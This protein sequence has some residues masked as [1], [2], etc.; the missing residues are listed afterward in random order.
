M[1][2]FYAERSPIFLAAR[3]NA[4]R[5]ANRGVQTGQGTPI[6]VV[7]PTPNPWVPL[8]ILALGRKAAEV[9]QADV[10][11]L[12]DQRPETLPQ[13]ERSK[14]FDRE[15]ARTDPGGQRAGVEP[16]SWPTSDPTAG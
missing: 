15:P 5:A 1:L 16:P 4:E 12:T 2:A 7:I 13:A 8:R 14:G 6:H 9:V 10:Y 11:L 3:F